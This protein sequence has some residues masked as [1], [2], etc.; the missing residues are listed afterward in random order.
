MAAYF[1]I[2]RNLEDWEGTEFELR[3]GPG[4]DER[5]VKEQIIPGA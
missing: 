4:P 1:I 3:P 5:V 2:Y